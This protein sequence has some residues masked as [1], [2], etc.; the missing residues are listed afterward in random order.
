MFSRLT[1]SSDSGALSPIADGSTPSALDRP[2]GPVGPIGRRILLVNVIAEVGIVVTGGLV[3]LTGSGLGC[4]TWPECTDGSLVPLTAQSEGFHKFV[5]F[6][7]RLLTFAVLVAA[8][9]A[10]LV[11]LRPWLA[12]RFTRLGRLAPPGAVRR[13]LLALAVAVI[14][15]IVGQAV[16]GGI[17][18]LLDLHPATVAAHF[19]LSI[20]MIGAAYLLYRRSADPADQ[21]VTVVVPRELQ[22]LARTLVVVGVGVL[23][24]GTVVTGSGPHSGDADVVT[25]FSLDV[26]M[27]SWLHADVVL[28]FV[29]LALAF[30]FAARLSG[31]PRA[32]TRAGLALLVACV[33]QGAIGYT[34]YFTG[35][36]VPLVSLHMLG[37]CLVWIATLEVLISTR[38]RGVRSHSGTGSGASVVVT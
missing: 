1:M 24:L 14:V 25:R 5:E 31:A 8:V 30:T 21:P 9:A 32:A 34:Q 10:L 36:P 4:P 23:A 15:G 2:V 26:R 18:V 19:L 20:A 6:G 37:A 11:V 12:V 17:T 22:W 33:V 38:R 29:G 7:N 28:V 27:I 16:L 13:P 35:V 3:R